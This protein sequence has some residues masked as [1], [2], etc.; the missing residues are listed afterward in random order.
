MINSTFIADCLL[1]RNN[2]WII[3]SKNEINIHQH[4]K[5]SPWF[6]WAILTDELCCNLKQ[7]TYR[8]T[9]IV[10]FLAS[11]TYLTRLNLLVSRHILFLSRSHLNICLDFTECEKKGNA[12]KRH[13]SPILRASIIILNSVDHYVRKTYNGMVPAKQVYS[14]LKLLGPILQNFSKVL[15]ASDIGEKRL[16]YIFR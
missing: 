9:F 7:R 14:Q 8:K 11:I 10:L 15:N 3:I 2:F 4:I 1:S 16:Y 5:P 12:Y 13:P 6:F